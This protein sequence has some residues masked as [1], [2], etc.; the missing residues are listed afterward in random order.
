MPA[1]RWVRPMQ[2]VNGQPVPS[3]KKLLVNLDHVILT[4]PV[5]GYNDRTTLVFA[6]GMSLL[7][8]A[9]PEEI[10]QVAE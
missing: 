4:Q 1:L 3:I 7:V 9:T 2:N 8:A 10:A 6:N 5:E